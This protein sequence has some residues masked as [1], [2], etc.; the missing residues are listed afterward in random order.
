M[1]E[2]QTA[3]PQSVH[4]NA[5][6]SETSNKASRNNKQEQTRKKNDDIPF[7]YVYFGFILGYFVLRGDKLWSNLSTWKDHA[8][9]GFIPDLQT[10][11][12]PLFAF[13]VV[14]PVLY[15]W[16]TLV[17]GIIFSHFAEK[18]A[19]LAVGTVKHEKF[20]EQAWLAV[21]YTIATGLGYAVLKDK[22]WFPPLV[23]EQAQI[24][25]MATAKERYDD[26][27]DFGLR[28]LYALQL[29]FYT[30]ELVTLLMTKHRRSDAMVYF[31]HHIYTMF[32]MGG[33]W[34]SYQHRI[35]TLVLFLHDIG[36]IFL[37]I[38]KCY[39][40]AEEHIRRT[41]TKAQYEM[42]K[43]IGMG[44][45]V[46]FVIA[47]AIPR[48]V[49]Y[50]T[51]VYRGFNDYPWYKCCGYDPLTQYCGECGTLGVKGPN[52]DTPL[53]GTLGLLYPMHVYWFYLIVKMALRL[54]L[55]PGQYDDVR[56]DDEK[57]D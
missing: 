9:S 47:F 40:Y 30:L 8:N 38:G 15:F 43:N 25:L 48:L 54:L 16:R 6:P 29:G 55:Q 32:L 44:C 10:A 51:L 35:G 13:F 4:P 49:V 23:T 11:S 33:S 52:W 3:V 36:D 1:I 28:A 18:W 50:G 20:C 39:T 2:T 17:K 22:P 5:R 41:R 37:P 26:Q 7:P 53:Q 46:M 57:E 42:H 21:H 31:F 19:G 56:S 34:I 45:F 24:A 14:C 27:Q 12:L